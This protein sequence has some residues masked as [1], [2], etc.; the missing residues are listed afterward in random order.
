MTPGERV[1]AAARTKLGCSE[2]PPGSNDGACVN[3]I[4]SSTGAYNLAWCGSFV[5][6]SY[7]KAGVGEDGL[8]SASTYQ[9]VGNAKA[10]GAL[11]PKPVPGCMIVWHPGSSGHT[12]VYIDA[13]RGFG[14]RTIG[15]NTG[16]AV[17]EH[18]RDIRGAYLIAPK[19]L[20][21]PPPP[22][23]RDVYWWEDPAATPDRHGLYAATASR[24]KAI[25]QWVAAGGQPGHVR[26]GKLSVLVEGKLR[27][28]YTFW[29]GPRKRSPDFSTKAKRDANLKKVSAQRPGHILRP[30]SRRE[31]LS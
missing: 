4:Q 27:P 17:R 23:F 26:R 28:R 25:R 31:R 19:A 16:D 1:I 30:R 13:G 29:T 15:G 18:F 8:C 22:V 21:E 10:Q 5:K 6:W 2:S 14:P 12:E 7:D 3:Q 24:E 11:I 9:M 20:R